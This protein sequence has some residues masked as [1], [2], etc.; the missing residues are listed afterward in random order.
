MRR[1]IVILALLGLAS[2]VANAA[3]VATVTL[4]YG[5]GVFD[6]TIGVDPNAGYEGLAIVKVP[7]KDYTTVLN[8]IPLLDCEKE[9]GPPG[10]TG[11]ESALYGF[12]QVRSADDVS[13]VA[14]AQD[15]VNGVGIW[16]G[17]GQVAGDM[18]YDDYY[19]PTD[20]A[21]RW[22]VR[23]ADFG[24]PVLVANGTYTGATP[25]FDD[26]DEFGVRLTVFNTTAGYGES[27]TDVTELD[28][29]TEIELIV[30]PEPA[31]LGLLTIGGIAVLLRRRRRA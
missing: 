12:H 27:N 23:N 9:A 3:I 8:Q 21:L 22:N 16:Y 10:P 24:A 13:P 15:T 25:D 17:V 2:G 1:A 5:S 30:I 11:N 14:A 29:D 20:F 7:L 28:Q 18:T 4:T 6:V 26:G 19:N 31:T